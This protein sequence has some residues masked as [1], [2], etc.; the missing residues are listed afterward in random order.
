MPKTK[1]TQPQEGEHLQEVQSADKRKE[2][3]MRRYKDAEGFSAVKKIARRNVSQGKVAA[4]QNNFEVLDNEELLDEEMV[5]NVGDITCQALGVHTGEEG[6]S[7]G[8][9]R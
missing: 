6:N 4:V 5:V 7:S 8:Q 3:M 1:Q 9:Y 2:V